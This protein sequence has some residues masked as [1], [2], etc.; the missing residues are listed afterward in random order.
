MGGING[1][2]AYLEHPI[3]PPVNF[4]TYFHREKKGGGAK[5]AGSYQLATVSFKTNYRKFVTK[6]VKPLFASPPIFFVKLHTDT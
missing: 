6:I 5:K 1:Q 4:L 2:L 3:S